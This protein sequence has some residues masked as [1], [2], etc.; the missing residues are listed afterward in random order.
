MPDPVLILH[1]RDKSVPA[2]RLAEGAEGLGYRAARAEAEDLDAAPAERI[3]A[4]RAAI[5]LWSK[6]AM[7]SPV[8]V[9]AAEEARRQGKL[10]EASA[11]GIMP[12]AALDQ[13]DAALISGWRG[14]P[15]HPGWQRIAGELRRLCGAPAPAAAPVTARTPA[16]AAAE[17]STATAPAAAAP[18][19]ARPKR[20]PALLMLGLALLLFAGLGTAA[21]MNGSSAPE[22]A[23]VATSVP[24]PAEAE[25]APV[26][27]EGD[28]LLPV[29]EDAAILP[30]PPPAPV[31]AEPARAAPAASP[32]PRPAAAAKAR[33][34]APARE[35]DRPVRTAA[36]SA[37]PSRPIRYRN[38]KNM[39][40]FCARSGRNTPQCRTFLRYARR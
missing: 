13:P 19:A 32:A 30:P 14:E 36:R 28:E 10:I 17:P 6:G 35:V 18:A 22:V 24:A 39:R 23:A 5:V 20:A 11:D 21:W 40:R 16:A 7:A 9:E 27:I 3:R 2:L 34:A 33:R 1:A 38:A 8:I 4:A 26:S 12:V 31:A 25:E 37:E 29:P 15:F